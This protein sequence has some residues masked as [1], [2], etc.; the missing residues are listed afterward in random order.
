MKRPGKKDIREALEIV[1]WD[2]HSIDDDFDR[3]RVLGELVEFAWEDKTIVAIDATL[4]VGRERRK[5]N[6]ADYEIAKRLRMEGDAEV[7]AW[8]ISRD[9]QKILDVTDGQTISKLRR[10][11]IPLSKIIDGASDDANI[12]WHPE[13]LRGAVSCELEADKTPTRKCANPSCQLRVSGRRS[14]HDNACKLR[15]FRARRKKSDFADTF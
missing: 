1:G 3:V 10:G 8:R 15:A 14:Y 9:G 4:P 6:R 5:L 11:L 12:Y 7:R 13:I 2:F